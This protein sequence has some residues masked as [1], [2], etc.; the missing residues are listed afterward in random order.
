MSIITKIL[1]LNKSGKLTFSKLGL[2][3]YFI[4]VSFFICLTNNSLKG[5]DPS[6]SQF[7]SNPIY[8]NP[9]LVGTNDGVALRSNYRNFWHKLDHGFNTANFTIDSEEPFLSGGLGLIA[10]SG[11]EGN[12]I[13]N[14][15][16]FGFAYSYNL[17]LN[18]RKLEMQ[19]GLQGAW[20]QKSINS[21]NLIF[22]DQLDP[23]HGIIGASAYNSSNM[24]KVSFPDFATGLNIRANLG[25]TQRGVAA[26]TLNSGF[27]LHHITQPNESFTGLSSNLPIKYI[28]YSSAIIKIENDFANHFLIMPGIILE[29]Q[30]NF[31]SIIVGSN[32]NLK[33]IIFG[34]WYRNAGLEFSSKNIKAI[35]LNAGI[36]FGDLTKPKLR[37]NYSY[38]INISTY[39]YLLGDAHEI[40]ISVIIPDFQL[41]NNVPNNKRAKSNRA[42]YNKF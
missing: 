3:R 7:F 15:T 14:S 25:K 19:M 6:F 34:L 32:I 28:I 12:G 27:A 1:L 16:M 8:Y 23:I 10:L 11:I 2:F 31:Q 17:T 18:P 42:C 22:S 24:E 5:Q 4:L 37:I 33:P 39:Q 26:A 20:V 30:N 38:D 41:F 40:S 21:N 35:T 29:Q 36:E 13:I 9:A